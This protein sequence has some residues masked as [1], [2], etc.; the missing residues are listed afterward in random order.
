MHRGVFVLS[1]R[2]RWVHLELK[3]VSGLVLSGIQDDALGLG[4]CSGP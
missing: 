3:R 2:K 1:D 4:G